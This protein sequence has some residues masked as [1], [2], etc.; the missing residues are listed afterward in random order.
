MSLSEID[1]PFLSVWNLP[2]RIF[3][4]S[5]MAERA[6]SVRVAADS[7]FVIA[8]SAQFSAAVSELA[9]AR[10]VGTA[11]TIQTCLGFLLTLATI[12]LVP[13]ERV[14]SLIKQTGGRTVTQVRVVASMAHL[15][16]AG[17]PFACARGCLVS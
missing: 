17:A 9:D 15:L 10:Y 13:A 12:G 14:E 7:T 5:A 8:D 4:P 16:P 3:D 2:A 1:L 11:L 6:V